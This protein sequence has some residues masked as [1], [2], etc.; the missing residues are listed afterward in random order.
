MYTY[1]IYE[2]KF[3][4]TIY[5]ILNNTDCAF[6]SLF[7]HLFSPLSV[8]SFHGVID[9]I[10]EDVGQDFL[11]NDHEEATS[12]SGYVLLWLLVIET[13]GKCHLEVSY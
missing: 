12:T 5:L 1:I 7:Y 9:S 13:I 3:L 6:L 11:F 4:W 8:S 10:L 2:A